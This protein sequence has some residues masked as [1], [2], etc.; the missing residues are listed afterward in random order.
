[1]SSGAG[2]VQRLV[3]ALVH[4]SARAKR[5]E[6]EGARLKAWLVA[7]PP[8][9]VSGSGRDSVP[10]IGFGGQAGR[11]AAPKRGEGGRE[12]G[13]A[14]VVGLW[15]G[16]RHAGGQGTLKRRVGKEVVV[17]YIGVVVR[18]VHGP[19]GLRAAAI[20]ERLERCRE[21]GREEE[22]GR[23]GGHRAEVHPHMLER[24]E[25]VATSHPVGEA[26]RGG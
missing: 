6:S 9:G 14:D 26:Q 18:H 25:A 5:Y 10:K 15:A 21:R 19:G 1:M 4:R 11:M 16:R 22:E 23:H 20:G 13:G 3:G 12:V 8:V 24:P 17:P 2:V 7:R